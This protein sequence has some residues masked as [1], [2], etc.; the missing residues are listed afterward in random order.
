M[1]RS[2]KIE[3]AKIASRTAI[4]VACI[5]A[6]GGLAAGYFAMKT[7][8]SSDENTKITSLEAR[9]QNLENDLNISNAAKVQAQNDLENLKQ[10]VR[11][12][13]GPKEDAIRRMSQSLE[14]M[15]GDVGVSQ[16]H[17]ERLSEIVE[18]LD[19]IDNKVLGIVE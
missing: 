14:R 16:D 4:L 6:V 5:A 3:S 9:I 18:Q 11:D 7:Q 8:G 15:K 12:I 19:R 1:K 17:R 10:R 13:L 2:S